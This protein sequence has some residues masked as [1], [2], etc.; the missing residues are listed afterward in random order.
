MELEPI[1][2]QH[3]K[4]ETMEERRKRADEAIRKLYEL[5]E[6]RQELRKLVDEKLH[7]RR[8]K[9]ASEVKMK[10]NELEEKSRGYEVIETSSCKPT[11]LPQVETVST[12][13]EQK[14]SVETVSTEIKPTEVVEAEVLESEQSYSVETVSTPTEQKY[15]LESE[16][17]AEIVVSNEQFG[18]VQGFVRS[19]NDSQ[20]KS[21]AHTKNPKTGENYH[22]WEGMVFIRGRWRKGVNQEFL[23]YIIKRNT[24]IPYFQKMKGSELFRATE[25]WMK[26]RFDEVQSLWWDFIDG[27]ELEEV[28]IKE[29]TKAENQNKRREFMRKAFEELDRKNSNG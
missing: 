18:K 26:Y 1:K 20:F 22:D 8:E 17:K 19:E 11:S 29:V 15:S 6:D 13:V 10:L 23:A 25:N 16:L 4:S 21:L 14:Y 9:D 12:P 5:P 28:T 27:V 3:K 24:H 7:L 2:N